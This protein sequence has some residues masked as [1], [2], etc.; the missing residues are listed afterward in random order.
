LKNLIKLEN[1]S[2]DVAETSLVSA[3]QAKNEFEES[4]TKDATKFSVSA[5]P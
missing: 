4:A 1:F 5:L 2:E 3:D